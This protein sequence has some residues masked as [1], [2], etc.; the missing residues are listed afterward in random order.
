LLIGN[1]AI[2]APIENQI[3][4]RL[5]RI[6]SAEREQH[7]TIREY[8]R[9]F[10]RRMEQLDMLTNKVESALDEIKEDIANLKQSCDSQGS[11]LL[12]SSVKMQKNTNF[13]F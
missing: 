7:T 10:T 5:T 2:D 4:S 1:R 11:G 3:H 12:S 13:S 9:D 6:E 8:M